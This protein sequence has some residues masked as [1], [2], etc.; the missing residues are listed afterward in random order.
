MHP[1]LTPPVTEDRQRC[2]SSSL[3]HKCACNG[4]FARLLPA[5]AVVAVSQAPSPESNPNSPSPVKAIVGRDRTIV[6]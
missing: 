6:S 3:P 5:L 4:Q 2:H 1:L